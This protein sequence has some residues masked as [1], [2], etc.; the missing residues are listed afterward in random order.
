MLFMRVF[1]YDSFQYWDRRYQLS[2]R[3]GIASYEWYADG[4]CVCE[5]RGVKRIYIECG[6]AMKLDTKSSILS[7]MRGV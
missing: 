7:C 3:K 1:K 5:A 6:V 2:S 4:V